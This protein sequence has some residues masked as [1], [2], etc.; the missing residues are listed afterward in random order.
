[1]AG[2][3]IITNPIQSPGERHGKIKKLPS[4]RFCDTLVEGLAGILV[5]QGYKKFGASDFEKPLVEKGLWPANVPLNLLEPDE[6]IFSRSINHVSN[7]FV[8]VKKTDSSVVVFTTNPRADPSAI[9]IPKDEAYIRREFKSGEPYQIAG[10]LVQEINFLSSLKPNNEYRGQFHNHLGTA[11]VLYPNRKSLLFPA[12]FDDGMTYFLDFVRAAALTHADIVTWTPHNWLAGANERARQ[13]MG[14]LFEILGIAFPTGVE[15]SC[16]LKKDKASGPHMVVIGE[17]EAL[18]QVHIEILAKRDPKISINSCY[19]GMTLFDMLPIITDLRKQGKLIFGFPHPWNDSSIDLG[20][21]RILRLESTGLISA[22]DTGQ[23]ALD[24][25]VDIARHAD[26]I[27]AFNPTLTNTDLEISNTALKTL[28]HNLI[29]RLPGKLSLT[30]HA[31]NMAIALGLGVN[32]TYDPDDHRILPLSSRSETYT[33]SGYSWGAGHTNMRFSADVIDYIANQ[34]RKMF[35]GEFVK[36][37]ILGKAI[38]HVKVFAEENHGKLRI[39]DRRKERNSIYERMD[40]C[41]AS[42]QNSTY[43]NEF[44]RTVG[45]LGSD[46]FDIIS[47]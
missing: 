16:P 32:Q 4:S 35:P 31:A 19:K 13:T 37:V 21:A 46:A 45:E 42:S 43:V 34:G 29:S 10:N 7:F 17:E 24:Q 20:L 1:M 8:F 14:A 25:A 33:G 30:T 12:L 18:R 27:G 3:H 41:L 38:L 11:G 44:L 9:A 26:F 39:N 22:V 2:P 47:G 36:S 6:Y 5:T 15:I 40:E 28:M 23:I